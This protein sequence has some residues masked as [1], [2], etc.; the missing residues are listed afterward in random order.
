M[1]LS[2]KTQIHWRRPTWCVGTH[3]IQRFGFILSIYLF[4]ASQVPNMVK[5]FWTQDSLKWKTTS[6]AKLQFFFFCEHY[7]PARQPCWHCDIAWYSFLLASVHGC[8]CTI[9]KKLSSEIDVTWQKCVLQCPKE[10]TTFWLHLTST[11]DIESHFYS[12]PVFLINWCYN[13]V[14]LFVCLSH[15]W[16]T[17]KCFN[18]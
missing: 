11:F 1:S 5:I 17:T 3:T 4:A 9:T 7:H 18:I 16:S 14:R 6:T 10:V 12:C 8:V 2:A 13:S 15:W